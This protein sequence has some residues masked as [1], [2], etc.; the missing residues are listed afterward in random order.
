MNRDT[1]PH[2][3]GA[4]NAVP[5][6][7][8]QEHGGNIFEFAGRQR[9]RVEEVTDF[10]ASINPLGPSPLA[11]QALQENLSSLVHYPDRACRP[12]REAL[13]RRYGLEIDQ[14]WVGNGSTELI[15]LIPR[16]LKLQRLLIPVPSF[17][18]YEIAAQL[19]G[20]RIDFFQLQEENNFQLRPAE[21]IQALTPET[22]ALFLCNPN[23]PTG[24]LLP[25]SDL[26]RI[27]QVACEKGI[28]V[29]LDEAFIDYAEEASLIGETKRYPNLIVLRSFTKFYAMPALRVGYLVSHAAILPQVEKIQ[30]PWSVNH[31]AQVAATA[32]LDDHDYIQKSLHVVEEERR[33]L[34]EAL[35]EL[36]GVALF[37]S[38]ANYLLLKLSYDRFDLDEVNAALLQ[39]KILVRNCRSFRGLGPRHLRIAV[40]SRPA[41]TKLIQLLKGLLS[42]EARGAL[43]E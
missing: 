42:K 27:V 7:S 19:A 20:C 24:Q 41:N 39:Q 25:K 6:L 21:L 13:A 34:S 32:S 35:S 10:S 15:H 8:N 11:L 12:V 36:E 30:A 28:K 38:Q 22:E 40:K 2:S 16:A 29:I 1:A 23:N 4:Q 9:C 18:E 14:I 33:Y 3:V 31:L 43:N 26:L 37:P 17:S 5:L